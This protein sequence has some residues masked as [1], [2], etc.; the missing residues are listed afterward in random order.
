MLILIN[1]AK[2][3][4]NGKTKKKFSLNVCYSVSIYITENTAMAFYELV[5]LT[6]EDSSFT[7][8]ST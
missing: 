8:F 1:K 7:H 6:L 3:K 4:I 2:K 5:N